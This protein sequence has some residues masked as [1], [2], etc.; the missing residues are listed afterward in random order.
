[1]DGCPQIRNRKQIVN[2]GLV[3]LSMADVSPWQLIYFK[4]FTYWRR[5]LSIF[6]GEH[7][8]S[9]LHILAK[10]VC[11][12]NTLY[13]LY[14]I[15]KAPAMDKLNGF[16]SGNQRRPPPVRQRNCLPLRLRTAQD[17][18]QLSA[19]ALTRAWHIGPQGAGAQ[20]VTFQ[21]GYPFGPSQNDCFSKE[22]NLANAVIDA[23]DP[24]N[25]D[26]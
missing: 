13:Q 10:Y 4:G 15:L 2:G 5:W 6:T 24:S 9:F 20:A 21:W 19:L 26:D 7:A 25:E 11:L 23:I 18:R 17:A 14:P 3:G 22:E 1:M 16:C 12:N 8:P